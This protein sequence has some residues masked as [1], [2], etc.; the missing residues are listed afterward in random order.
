MHI[1]KKTLFDH[2]L[3]VKLVFNGLLSRYIFLREMD[4]EW[5]YVISFKLLSWKVSFERKDYNT[6]KGWGLGRDVEDKALRLR[7]LYLS[8]IQYEWVEVE[9]RVSNLKILEQR[10]LCED[11][12]FLF[13]WIDHDREE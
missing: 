6:I 1:F 4:D 9:Q 7:Q 2:F 8:N 5:D 11:V 3:D 10:G 13:H 12:A